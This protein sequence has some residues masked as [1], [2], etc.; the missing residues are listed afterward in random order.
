LQGNH[1]NNKETLKIVNFISYYFNIKPEIS[2][3]FKM[4][5]EFNT[6]L[7]VFLFLF[8][9]ILFILKRDERSAFRLTVLNL[10][11]L[12]VVITRLLLSKGIESSADRLLEYFISLLVFSEIAFTAWSYLKSLKRLSSESVRV[13]ELEDSLEHKVRERTKHIEDVRDSLSGYAVQ[14]FEL[15]Q[16][17]ELKNQEILRQKDDIVKKSEK[18]R[19]ASDEIKKLDSFKKQMTRMIIHDLKNPLNVIINIA[20]KSDLPEKPAGT[21]RRISYGMLDLVLNILDISKFEDS[22]MTVS[23]SDFSFNQLV[24]RSIDKFSF[25]MGNASLE[26]KTSIPENCILRADEKLVE[27]IL[28]NLLSNSAHFTTAGGIIQVVASEQGDKIKIEVKDDGKGISEKLINKVFD[29]YIHNTDE[30]ELH[31]SSTGIGLTFCKLAVE[32]QG[33]EIGLT[34]K[35]GTG[36]TVWFL[37]KKGIALFPGN[38]IETENRTMGLGFQ[39]GE[40]TEDDINL[41]SP[42]LEEIKNANL[43]EISSIMKLLSNDVFHINK[44]LKDWKDALEEAVYSGDEKRFWMLT[45]FKRPDYKC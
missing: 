32:A 25:L 31:G 17:L 44:R 38:S 24:N 37:L 15:A 39:T 13:K 45:D 42:I 21:I 16:E 36:T 6:G 29:E 18:L 14:K 5:F 20:D 27:R 11:M 30:S 4:L 1:K 35:S 41:I 8:Y 34:S 12:F 10:I 7:L 9:L 22:K 33:G 43:Y 28:E 19:Q 40:L 23:L 26:L 3:T 2:N